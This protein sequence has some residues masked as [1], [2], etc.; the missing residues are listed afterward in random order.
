MV[1]IKGWGQTNYIRK[2]SDADSLIDMFAEAISTALNDAKLKLSDIDGFAVSSFTL[3][4]DRAID[5]AVKFNLKVNW[6]MDGSTGGAS[7]IDMLQHAAS[8][9]K[10]KTAKNILLLSGDLFKENEF[11]DLVLNYNTNTRDFLSPAGLVGPNPLFA[12][13]TTIQMNKYHFTKEDYGN[14]V[15]SQRKHANAN[16][17]ALYRDLLTM[18][19]YLA[20]PMISSPLGLYDCVPVVSGASA[21]IVGQSSPDETLENKLQVKK[22]IAK[23]NYDYHN[24]DGT[25]TGLSEIAPEFWD[26]VKLKPEEINFLA[27]YDDY[28]AIVLA[29]LMDL[30]YV[31]RENSPASFQNFL[32]NSKTQLNSSG[33]Q[34]TCGQN[35]AGGGMHGLI[36][37]F[38]GLRNDKS[39]KYGLACGYGMVTYRYGSCSNL[40]LIEVNR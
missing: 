13:L 6:I 32:E 24:G 22:I 9:I 8:A 16:P 27:L 39:S 11:A 40:V 1:V 17:K 30:G 25:S 37:I 23:H 18:T 26:E 4:P 19:E 29:Q 34:L 14:I 7:G 12:L 21:I 2:P 3:K 38:E 5:L 36:E 33:G 20:A 35:G 31:S 15:I 28:P 10:D